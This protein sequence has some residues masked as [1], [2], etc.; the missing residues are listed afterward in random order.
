MQN[1]QNSEVNAGEKAFLGLSFPWLITVL[2]AVLLMISVVN[3]NTFGVFFKPIAEDFDWSRA[4]V[5]GAVAI[6][7]FV[8][9]VF[10]IPIGYWTDR[11]GPRRI[12]L[13]SFIIIG[14]S[15]LII[16]QITALWQL[17][18]AQGLLMGIGV[19]GP[20]IALIA[21]VSKWHD[22]RRGIALG[23]ASVGVGLGS[24][25]FPPIAAKLI[26]AVDWR[27]AMS[28]L[29][30]MVLAI[31]VPGSLFLK[32][33]PGTAKVIADIRD[34]E[35]SGLFGIWRMLPQFL[36]NRTFLT[37]V[38]MFFLFIITVQMV[39]NHFVNYAT[40][41]GVSAVTAA[42]MMSALGIG[43]ITGRLVVGSVSDWTGIRVAIALCFSLF[44]VSLILM[45]WNVSLWMMWVSVILFGFSYGGEMPLVPGIIAERFGTEHLTTIIGIAMS[46]IFMGAS[47][48][49]YMGGLL[50]DLLD[51]YFGALALCA[52][53]TM[54]S[55]ILVLRLGPA[56]KVLHEKV[57]E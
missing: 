24:V 36:K 10:A 41:V 25:I 51:G 26:E 9:A 19:S 50:F 21:V 46:I 30:V 47:V 17:Y 45:N 32:N 44:T 1:E 40:D 38:T 48:G 56:T 54:I 20:F 3:M 14:A 2:V 55:L 37:V 33:P 53:F 16:A 39:L 5:S 4:A 13:P 6:R 22:R 42:S 29:G 35:Q 52:V 31:G 23:I 7:G 18:M 43:S 11:Y 27:F 15:L 57:L 34:I 12:I 8:M 28:M 49:P